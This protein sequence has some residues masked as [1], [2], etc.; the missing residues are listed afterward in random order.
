MFKSYSHLNTAS[1][2]CF[3]MNILPARLPNSR[4]NTEQTFLPTAPS[5]RGDGTLKCAT[6]LRHCAVVVINSVSRSLAWHNFLTTG[7]FE[8]FYSNWLQQTFFA[9]PRDESLRKVLRSEKDFVALNLSSTLNANS[10]INS[11]TLINLPTSP[12]P[13]STG[14]L[15]NPCFRNA[16][17]NFNFSLK[18][19]M[20]IFSTA[21]SHLMSITFKNKFITT[22]ARGERVK[23]EKHDWDDVAGE[24]RKRISTHIT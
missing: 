5:V 19:I 1:W 11:E 4:S 21:G 23:R 24:W 12:N 16:E 7:M 20:S 18:F 3:L 22:T 13:G 17:L 14:F 10:F 15:P 2:L 6:D 9:A 8:G